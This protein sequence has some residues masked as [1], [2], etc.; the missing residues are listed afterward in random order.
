MRKFHFYV[1]YALLLAIVLSSAFLSVAHADDAA[2]STSGRFD[3]DVCSLH[4]MCEG[5]DDALILRGRWSEQ[6]WPGVFLPWVEH[7]LIHA[8]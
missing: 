2:L 8:M 1:L 6:I 4:G 7:S 5:V 3:L